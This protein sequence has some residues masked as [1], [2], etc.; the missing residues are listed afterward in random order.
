MNKSIYLIIP[1]IAFALS[2]CQ[3][4][5]LKQPNVIFVLADQWRASDLG[6]AGN[7]DVQ[8][9]LLDKLAEEGINLENTIS[10]VPVCCPYRASLLTGQYALSHG[11]FYND[12]PLKNE[13]NSMAEIYKAA[14]YK[15]AYIGKWHL[16]GTPEPECEQ[17][18]FMNRTRPVVKSR[19]QGF[20]YWKVAECTHGYNNSF[21]FDEDN[22][23]HEWEGYDAIAQ[24]EDAISYIKAN[25]GNPFLLFLSWGP[26]H[27]PYHTAPAKDK[28]KYVDLEITLQPNVPDDE[29]E[30]AKEEIRGYYAHCS[31]LDAC[32]GELQ[33]AIKEAGI[34]E[35]TIFV[36][37][38]DHGDMLHSHGQ[39]KK[40][41]A[42]D[43]SIRVPFLL[44]YP[45]LFKQANTISTPFAT[46]DILPTLLGLSRLEIPG[47]IEGKDFSAHLKGGTTNVTA[48]L[49]SCPVPFHQWNRKKGGREFRG[50]R[51]QGHTYVRDLNGPWLLFDN[52]KDPYQLDNLA[53]NSDFSELQQEL[54][55]ELQSLLDQKGDKFR[56]A[57]YYMDKWGYSWAP[58]DITN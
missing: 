23:R 35:N 8:T 55:K 5:Q 7:R 58:S 24:T 37:T 39:V 1:F 28:E 29:I 6:Y 47:T 43:E 42:Y 46:E 26:P 10:T 22:Q 3:T 11:V 21:Y 44:K 18:P 20:E 41:Q 15:T 31:A 9:P 14:G 32:I 30:V 54:E 2:S 25:T 51:T 45:A 19:R 38:S 48:A 34:E 56:D 16:N 57:Q 13:V 4:K 49:I 53:N 52:D 50:I 12:K 36:F 17:E 33:S 27:A 40:Q